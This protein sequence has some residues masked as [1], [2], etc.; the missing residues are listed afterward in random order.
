[1]WKTS[2]ESPDAL[3]DTCSRTGYDVGKAT[4]QVWINVFQNWG[5]AQRSKM[6]VAF[7]ELV[8]S[9][10]GDEEYD[11][12]QDQQAEGK[13]VA[14]SVPRTDPA[15]DVVPKDDE[16]IRRMKKPSKR[17]Q[18]ATAKAKRTLDAVGQ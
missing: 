1:M 9:H 10:K 12:E 6:P 17:G 4:A 15:P 5:S 8:A 11:K 14:A 18:T 2:C 7:K 16:D 13:D 3:V